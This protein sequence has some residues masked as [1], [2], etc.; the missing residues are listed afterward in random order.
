MSTV[1]TLACSI[2]HYYV[3]CYYFPPTASW[4][5]ILPSWML[6][7][8]FSR[9]SL[10]AL[11]PPLYVTIPLAALGLLSPGNAL[12]LVG[13]CQILICI[14]VTF[15]NWRTETTRRWSVRAILG[16]FMILFTAGAVYDY[17]IA[18]TQTDAERLERIPAHA[19]GSHGFF[20]LVPI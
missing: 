9:K 6:V 10:P 20:S 16:T 7:L 4:N 2:C 5:W 14:I 18:W 15:M 19:R 8:S 13:L 17:G 12:S 11:F 3:A 1:P